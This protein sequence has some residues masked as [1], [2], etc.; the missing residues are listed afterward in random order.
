MLAEIAD[1]FLFPAPADIIGA[2]ISLLL[3]GI[4]VPDLLSTLIKIFVG[5]LVGSVSGLAIGFLLYSNRTVY[6]STTPL[7]DFGRSIPATALFPLFLLFFG[8]GDGTNIALAVWICSL[9]MALHT[10]E[11]LKNTNRTRLMAAKSL[12]LSGK[13]VFFKIKLPEAL[14]FVFVGLRTSIS[15]S[16]VVVVVTEMFIGTT[17]GLGKALIDFSYTYEIPSL[18]A[19]IAIVGIIG[20]ILNRLLITL[21]NKIVHWK[22]VL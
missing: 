13:D 4:I 16:I 22:S 11:G 18:Y 10:A 9:Y 17:H 1:I 20:F 3:S 21:E 7:I 12:K 15:L 14:P 6:E 19:T 8:I 2:M 5:F